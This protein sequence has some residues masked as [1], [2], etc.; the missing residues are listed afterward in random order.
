MVTV[1]EHCLSY[2]RRRI[3][4][5]AVQYKL[6]CCA[7]EDNSEMPR[8]HINCKSRYRFQVAL[9]PTKN[10]CAKWPDLEKIDLSFTVHHA[11]T[12]AEFLFFLIM[13]YDLIDLLLTSSN[14]DA[15]YHQS[16]GGL[17]DCKS[18]LVAL[19]C[20]VPYERWEKRV[21]FFEILPPN[22]NSF[23]T[24][25]LPSSIGVMPPRS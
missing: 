11:T 17:R 13:E 14:N 5:I 12:M 1:N 2:K 18:G 10:R 23:S 25:I 9:G 8:R 22:F 24:S 4:Q 7:E 19:V 20:F 21:G 6:E 3:D 16:F 15:R